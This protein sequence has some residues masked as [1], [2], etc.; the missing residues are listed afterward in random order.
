M[1]ARL[2]DEE[3]AFFRESTPWGFI[4]F[5]RIGLPFG[6]RET[7]HHAE[8]D[9]D[10]LEDGGAPAHADGEG[11]AIVRWLARGFG[12]DLGG[13]GGVPAF[14]AFE[15]LDGGLARWRLFGSCNGGPCNGMMGLRVDG[16]RT[17]AEALT[18]GDV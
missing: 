13:R 15:R 16:S 10:G 14:R 6:D 4:L 3:R 5:A 7:E 9:E 11:R 1:G 8:D 18:K 2:S 12:G 17:G